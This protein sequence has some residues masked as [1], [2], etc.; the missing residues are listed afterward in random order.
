MQEVG[1]CFFQLPCSY[2][3]GK[4]LEAKGG[5][6]HVTT[7]LLRSTLKHFSFSY[8]WIFLSYSGKTVLTVRPLIKS[9]SL[10]LLVSPIALKCVNT[11]Y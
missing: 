5:E 3:R 6:T 11:T 10:S 1:R 8:L 2:I 7:L 9:D 4:G